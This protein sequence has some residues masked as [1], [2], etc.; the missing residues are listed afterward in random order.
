MISQVCLGFSS[1]VR[2]EVSSGSLTL[3]ISQ[4][5]VEEIASLGLRLE[6]Q[7]VSHKTFD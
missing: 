2:I 6:Y 4:P 7:F 5:A 3:H 1:S